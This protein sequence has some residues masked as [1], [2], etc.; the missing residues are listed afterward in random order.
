[1]NGDLPRLRFVCF[2]CLMRMVSANWSLESRLAPPWKLL[3]APL[4][5][6][7]DLSLDGFVS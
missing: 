7:A 6:D 3:S 4:I 1:M 2:H 5:G